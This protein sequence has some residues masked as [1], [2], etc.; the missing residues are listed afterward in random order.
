MIY[1]KWKNGQWSYGAVENQHNLATKNKHDTIVPIQMKQ[2][3][4]SLKMLGVHLAPDGNQE[5]QYKYMFKKALQLGEFMKNGFVWKDEAF[6]ALKSI[7]L[8][9]IEYPLPATSL[10]EKQLRLIMWQL[11][12]HY[13]PKSGINRYINRDVLYTELKFQGMNVPNPYILQ[14]C[15]HIHDMLEHLHKK[16]ITGHLIETSLELLRVELGHNLPIFSKDI[17]LIKNLQITESWVVDVWRFCAEQQI[18]LN[19]NVPTLPFLCI[20]DVCIMDQV[21][22][23]KKIHLKDIPTINRCHLFLRAFMLSDITLGDGKH[24]SHE[25]WT[26]SYSGPTGREGTYWP[27][28]PQPSASDWKKWRD[29]LRVV[30]CT[31]RT[32]SL[33]TPLGAWNK[34]PSCLWWI[35]PHT[36]TLFQKG[37]EKWGVYYLR[38]KR[39]RNL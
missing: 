20:N 30:F 13:L 34:F 29:V 12:Q 31:D 8:K 38:S 4:E 17:S 28:I 22:K 15:Q 23:C 16:S 32:L 35:N 26:G 25:A 9:T 24:I 7:A 5:E 14:G 36:K 39:T 11:L 37:N 2:P 10:S 1:F 3:N 19:V 33:D 18:Q 27:T 6:L 21:L